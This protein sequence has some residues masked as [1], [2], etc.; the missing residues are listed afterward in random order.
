MKFS[1]IKYR[2][3]YA[4]RAKYRKKTGFSYPL[5]KS[6]KT[7]KLN[8]LRSLDSYTS[9]EK[10]NFTFL[11]LEKKFDK[12]IDWNFLDYGKLWAYNI[13][14]FEYLNQNNFDSQVGIE[15]IDEFIDNLETNQ[16]GMEPYPIALRGINWI[17]F[18]ITHDICEK[19]I[20]DSLLAQY[21]ILVDNLEYHLLGNHLLENG[22]SLLFGAYYFDDVLLYSKA[23]EILEAEL[24]EQI[25]EDG[26]HFELSP[27][28]HQIMLYRVLDCIN[29]VTHNNRFADELEV[30]LRSKAQM[31]LSWLMQISYKDDTIPHFSDSADGI[32]PTSSMLFKYAESLNVHIDTLLPLSESGYR[33]V[34]NDFY[35]LRV[36]VGE[37]GPSYIPGHGHSDTFNFELKIAGSPFIVDTGISTYE[38][39]DK[40]LKQRQTSAHNT[41]QIENFEQSEV[42]SSFRVA[43]RAHII[44]LKEEDNSIIATHDGYKKLGIKHQRT[45]LTADKSIEIRDLMIDEGKGNHIYTAYLHFHPSIDSIKIEEEKIITK[46]AI[47]SIK[48]SK[49]LQLDDFT[50]ANGFNKHRDAKVLKVTFER[51]LLVEIAIIS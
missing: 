38:S 39:N 47:L 27:M 17:K 49:N 41:V 22:Y 15:I 42:W 11:N 4:L 23:K 16:E 6:S 37:I 5:V 44:S 26:V 29:I 35:E 18:L 2:V 31:M 43:N 13:N 1:Q 3:F 36:D 8:F 48:G 32:A 12:Q 28:Y 9:Y 19:R 40:R 51:D 46:Y 33:K 21:Y 20:N 25:L 34:D 7:V 50:F 10:E 14:Y 45:F 30:L 24:E